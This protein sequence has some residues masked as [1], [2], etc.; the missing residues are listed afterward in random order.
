MKYLQKAEK[1]YPSQR[2]KDL[3]DLIAKHNGTSSSE[4]K[5]TENGD[6]PG[7]ARRR[8]SA[9]S[10][11]G[12]ATSNSRD[13]T[14]NPTPTATET[15]GKHGEYTPEQVDAVKRIKKAKDYY[16]I[17]N[18]TK[19]AGESELK[20]QYRK[21]ALQF[22]PDKNKAPGAVE[23]FKAIGNAFAV[24]SDPEKRKR[25]DLYGSD[26]QV[27]RRGHR[28]DDH[29]EYD[30]TR[31]FESDMT[32]EELF[33][34][35]FGGGFPSAG[36]VYVRRGNR[37]AR[38]QQ[39]QQ[40][41]YENHQSEGSYSALLQML[42]ILILIF[43]SLMSSFFVSEPAFSL[44]RSAK[45]PVERQT[46][47]LRIPYYVKD[48]FNSEYQGSIRRIEQQVEEEYVTSLRASCIREKNYKESMLWRAR[49]FGDAE[50]LRKANG[51]RTPS[52]ETL[53]GLYS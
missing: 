39:Q 44:Q 53:Q 25:Y 19:E 30:Y 35:F 37:W 14:D 38:Y 33:N 50:L 13:S 10:A 12:G 20:K 40:Q 28:G 51:L 26:E 24:L 42:P 45:Y 43:L 2:A 21:L 22:H 52:C 9:A 49:N 41:H 31:G 6:A 36:N 15:D 11:G 8:S 32:A 34:M 4:G 46:R 1:L 48:T 16:E 27:R 23:A 5:P 47:H 18:V 17:L 29:Y 3:V 7:F